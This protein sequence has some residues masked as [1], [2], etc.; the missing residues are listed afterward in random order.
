M[1]AIRPPDA[2]PEAVAQGIGQALGSLGDGI[3]AAFKSKADEKKD[4]LKFE[5]DKE[6]ARIKAQA[7]ADYRRETLDETSRHNRA[8]EEVARAKTDGSEPFYVKG[9]GQ[10]TTPPAS[11]QTQTPED[12]YIKE[13]K[14]GIPYDQYGNQVEA[15]EYGSIKDPKGLI[16][17]DPNKLTEDDGKAIEE[18]N[19]VVLPKNSPLRLPS[20]LEG[21]DKVEPLSFKANTAFNTP[22]ASQAAT[23]TQTAALS[24]V[25]APIA[26][27]TAK[28]PLDPVWKDINAQYELKGF[29]PVGQYALNAADKVG[30]FF[31]NLPSAEKVSGDIIAAGKQATQPMFGGQALASVP[32]VSGGG[33][34]PISAG[35]APSVIQTPEDTE[36]RRIRE[37]I[38]ESTQ[39]PIAELAPS[40]VAST[41]SGPAMLSGMQPLPVNS[42]TVDYDYNPFTGGVFANLPPPPQGKVI[43]AGTQV[44]A[45][46]PVAGKQQTYNIGYNPTPQDVIGLQQNAIANDRPVTGPFQSVREAQQEAAKHYVGFEPEGNVKWSRLDKGYIVE[47]PPVKQY[48]I[49]QIDKANMAGLAYQNEQYNKDQD[50][51]KIRSQHR[52]LNGFKSAFNASKENPATQNITDLDMIDAYVAFA[53]GAGSVTGGGVAVTENQYNEIKKG[54]SVPLA[55][56][57]SI[58]SF[59]RGNY[60]TQPE[61]DTMLKTMMEAYNNQARIVN[62]GT[63]QMR[64]SLKYTNRSLPEALM[65]HEYPILR[66]DTEI[67]REKAIMMRNADQLEREIQ[68]LPVE[69]Q[70]H[71]DKSSEYENIL[72]NLR[73]LGK[74]NA[75]IRQN[76]GLPLNIDEIDDQVIEKSAGWR[77]GLFP[78]GAIIGGDYE[79][80]SNEG[81]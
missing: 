28:Q 46:P 75:V 39:R 51:T 22:S 25:S 24:N 40:V 37:L 53:R 79:G 7:D 45:N 49:A 38:Q 6:L 3:T 56:Q 8:S 64:E 21:Y 61:R 17:S 66:T 80:S 78:K 26:R 30:Q 41:E 52:L 14:N 60:L 31:A 71:K 32:P 76:N 73:S 15:D 1:S 58:E 36:S 13:V 57:K 4:L 70:Q 44:T 33:M 54:K 2:Q 65:P 62:R 5:R 67:N 20:V 55:I 59:F 63:R 48:R 43:Q 81:Q 16:S 12:R 47:R 19:R 35:T 77:Q 42:Q 11:Q 34:Q 18:R 29:V 9:S 68:R 50:V 23:Q 27:T 74:E 69:S 10:N 72:N